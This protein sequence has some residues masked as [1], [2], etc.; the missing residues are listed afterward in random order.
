MHYRYLVIGGGMTGDAAVRGIREVDSRSTIGVVGAEPD[1]PYDRPPLTKG[2]WT[3]KKRIEDVWRWTEAQGVDL[4][5]GRSV[6]SIDLGL[7]NVTDDRGTSFSYERLLIATG[8]TPRQLPYSGERVIHLRTMEHYRRLRAFAARNARFLVVGGGFIG[9]EIAASLAINGCHVTMAFQG[10]GV[11]TRVLPAGLSR[12]VTAMFRERG[13]EVLPRTVAAFAEPRPDC[14][15]VRLRD[16]TALTE[17]TLDVDAMVVGIGIRPAFEL[18]QAAGLD[19]ED[20]IVVDRFLRTSHPDVY[21]A[22]DVAA[23]P[24]APLGR[25][26]RVEHEDNAL[27][28]GQTAGRNMAGAGEPYD[29]LPYFY[30]DLFDVG[31]EAVGDTSPRLQVVEDWAKPLRKGFVYYLSGGHVRGVLAFNVFG[32]MDEARAV[33]RETRP[34]VPGDLAGRIEA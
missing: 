24:C 14:L 2:L 31:Y 9:S 5:L 33:I 3:G 18:A 1:P 11:A 25:R 27:S 8:G 34:I 21:A 16:L 12:F 4:H 20:G 30:S 10:E 13:V 22:G 28:A 15:R 23:F 6:R 7:R 29:H 19:V 17:R 32:K 26:T